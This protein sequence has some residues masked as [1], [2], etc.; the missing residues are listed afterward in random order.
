MA[1]CSQCGAQVEGTFCSKCGASASGTPAPGV[2]PVAT[3]AGMP[4]NTASAL[5][6]LFGLITGVIFLVIEPYNKD[7]EVRFHAFQSIFLNVALI[8]VHIAITFVSVMFHAVS[9]ALGMLV[10]SINILISLVFFLLWIF[11][12]FKTYQGGKVVLPIIGPLAEAQAGK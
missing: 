4:V 12:L 9:F 10:G 7:R 1:F 2:A 11:L 6:Y 3:Q 8:V 5:C